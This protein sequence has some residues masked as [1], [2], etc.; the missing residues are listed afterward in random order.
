MEMTSYDQASQTFRGI[1][2]NGDINCIVSASRSLEHY[3]LRD[4]AIVAQLYDADFQELGCWYLQTLMS[5][6]SWH[7]F[8]ESKWQNHATVRLNMYI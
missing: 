3:H 8:I 2:K 6:H 5:C 4:V 1:L 7:E